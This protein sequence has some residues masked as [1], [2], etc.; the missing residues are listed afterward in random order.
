[1]DVIKKS[2]KKQKFNKN[3]IVKSC[4][5]VGVPK[6]VCTDIADHIVGECYNGISTQEIRLMVIEELN[7]R[8][9][10]SANRYRNHKKEK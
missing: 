6:K 2:G 3:K 8:R 9:E 10:K 4:M 1:M 5:K 7:R